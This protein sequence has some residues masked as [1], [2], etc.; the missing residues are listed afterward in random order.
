MDIRTLSLN[1]LRAFEAAARHLNFT[2]AA[3]ELCVT[4]AAVS[5]QV[6]MLEAHVGKALFRR[7]TRG[8]V[9]SDEG[10]LLAPVVSAALGR[11]AEALS[12]IST[13]GVREVLTIGVVGTF[14]LGFL[15]ERLPE[16]QALHP[17]I[18]VR[19]LTNNNAVDLWTESLDVAI[20][21]GDGSWHGVTAER[22]MPAPMTPAC[23]PAM[24]GQ[25]VN[26]TDLARF[27]LLRSYRLQDW[28]TWFEAAGVRGLI[29][30]GPIFDASH[31]M[32]LA[33]ARGMGIALLP[34]PMFE[35]ERSAGQLITPF[36]ITVDRGSYWLTRLS[37]KPVSDAASRFSQWLLQ[38]AA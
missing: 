15:M 13:G 25:I 27:P 2:R 36:D 11:V 20:R 38:A 9:L 28:S 1:T 24:A 26:V 29:A 18:D 17:G 12:V 4:Q 31:L 34:L 8:L 14:A 7:T 37:S 23:C 35:R 3:D 33:A 21:F 22:L 10:A 32:A 5:Q 6:K 30:N 16:F 19:M